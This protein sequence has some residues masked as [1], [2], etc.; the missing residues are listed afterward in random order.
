MYK[1]FNLTEEERQQILESHKSHGYKKPLNEKIYD[2]EYDVVRGNPDFKPQT[3]KPSKSYL[4]KRTAAKQ[5]Q[6][7]FQSEFP[8]PGIEVKPYWE[9]DQAMPSGDSDI[10]AEIKRDIKVG[11][12]WDVS[13]KWYG[14]PDPRL[15]PNP[16]PDVIPNPTPNVGPNLMKLDLEALE[17]KITAL[18]LYK[19]EFGLDEDMTELY[20]NLMIKYKEKSREYHRGGVK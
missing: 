9:K 13:K 1:N 11:D 2:K 3:G 17:K 15:S 8:D 19:N 6:Q 16:T 12:S 4:E 7:D 5:F 20:N 10:D 18:R 14:K